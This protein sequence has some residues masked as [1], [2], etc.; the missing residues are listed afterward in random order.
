MKLAVQAK[1]IISAAL[2]ETEN[3]GTSPVTKAD[4]NVTDKF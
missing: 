4:S 1:E 2:E 3:K